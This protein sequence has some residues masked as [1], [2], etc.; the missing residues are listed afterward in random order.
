MKAHLINNEQFPYEEPKYKDT[1][2]RITGQHLIY[3]YTPDVPEARIKRLKT[4]GCIDIRDLAEERVLATNPEYEELTYYGTRKKGY[5]K[6]L[7]A[8]I[9]KTMY[10]ALNKQPASFTIITNKIDGISRKEGEMTDPN[11]V[12]GKIQ[13]CNQIGVT[14]QLVIPETGY[15]C[16]IEPACNKKQMDIFTKEFL[17]EKY[18]T[19]YNNGALEDEAILSNIDAVREKCQRLQEYRHDVQTE[20]WKLVNLKLTP[21]LDEW[22]KENIF[23]LE[24][25]LSYAVSTQAEEILIKYAIDLNIPTCN[26]LT[27][28]DLK[29][30]QNLD[31]MLD[32]IHRYGPAFGVIL[33]TADTPQTSTTYIPVEWLRDDNGTLTESVMLKRAF[34][35][36]QA[37][38]KAPLNE[39]VQAYIQ[40]DWYLSHPNMVEFL[41][42]GHSVCNCSEILS[43]HDEDCFRCGEHNPNFEP[44]SLSYDTV[45]D[46]VRRNWVDYEA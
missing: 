16:I 41:V 37:L 34:Q 39:L 33:K 13:L 43:K 38:K 9:P 31:T 30:P 7:N 2:Y 5:Y 4:Q 10:W 1:H 3:C 40:I 29:D 24:T 45:Q 15:S 25:R 36:K 23:T 28:E 14:V 44:D 19:M 27:V 20:I 32:T 21:F 35:R 18:L 46:C 6:L 17:C 8:Q 22:K 12:Y 26:R 11:T 42:D